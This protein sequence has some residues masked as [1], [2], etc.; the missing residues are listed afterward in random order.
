MTELMGP[1]FFIFF[2]TEEFIPE[3]DSV[4]TTRV[5]PD[6]YIRPSDS[7]KQENEA[8]LLLIMLK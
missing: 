3:A 6:V 8:A 7:F 1:G 5:L 4:Y 2:Q